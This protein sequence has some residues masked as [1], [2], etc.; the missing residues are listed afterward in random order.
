MRADDIR[1]RAECQPIRQAG[2]MPTVFCV[3]GF[4][5]VPAEVQLACGVAESLGLAARA[6]LLAG[7]GQ[8]SFELSQCGY[9]DWLSGLQAEF[10][11]ARARGPVVL[12][13]LSLGSLLAT[14]LLLSAPGD[15][16]GL[17]LLANAFWLNSP[18]PSYALAAADRTGLRGIGIRKGAPDLGEERARESHVSYQIQPLDSAL[19]L[20]RAGAR[21][22]ERLHRVH[23]PT[24]ILHGAKDRVCPV[25]N[26][27]RAAERL[28]TRERRVVI[29]PD[30][31][32]ILTRDRERDVVAQEL[33]SFIAGLL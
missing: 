32:H 13:G 26:A 28:G 16:L 24:L 15:V 4:T 5:G 25:S 1:S 29:Y 8:S 30:S 3:H 9:Q 31:R 17:A 19:S 23:R 2:E 18:Y 6:P 12:V 14:D 33:K 7:H 22:R 20:F 11:S 21:V 10:D 27:W